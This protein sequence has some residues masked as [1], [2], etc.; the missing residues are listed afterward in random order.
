MFVIDISSVP[1]V[2]DAAV[3]M[4]FAQNQIRAIHGYGRI[5]IQ[6]VIQD[7][8]DQLSLFE[9]G[10]WLLLILEKFVPSSRLLI[11]SGK[12]NWITNLRMCRS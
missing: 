11:E 8:V 9:L 12:L 6:C 7:D 5:G 10:F 3:E 2:D 1:E 4:Q